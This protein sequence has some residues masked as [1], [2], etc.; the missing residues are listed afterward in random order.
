[1]RNGN[2]AGNPSTLLLRAVL[3]FVLAAAALKVAAPVAVPVVFSFYLAV[4]VR[5]LDM[6][7]RSV[8]PGK[9]R[10]L[11]L[12]LTL[13][14]ILLA[15]ALIAATVWFGV[16]QIRDRAPVYADAAARQWNSLLT[17]MDSHDLP[18]REAMGQFPGVI[19]RM[20]SFATST[21]AWIWH[22]AVLAMIIFFFTTLLLVEW[23]A[24][25]K[26]A[27]SAVSGETSAKVVSVV[28]TISVKVRAYLLTRTAVS[29]IS[30]LSAGLWL[31]AAGV[32]LAFVWGFLTFVLNYI[33][34][35]GS[36][37]SV[38]APSLLAFIQLGFGRAVLA[39]TGL[40][41]IEQIVGM[42]L[43]PKMQGRAMRVSPFVLLVSML[44]WGWMWGG[45]GVI[46]SV[47][48]TVTLLAVFSKIDTLEPAAVLMRKRAPEK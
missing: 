1:M 23:E 32:D 40:L 26:R 13:L 20:V 46:L 22:G 29:L 9:L 16:R 39:A 42:Y 30:G 34:Y 31:W 6:R 18:F 38:I 8:L 33:P 25:I 24:W 37:L 14:V 15:A 35:L 43:E 5:P 19:D 17:W 45:L 12:L 3:T 41:A 28:E 27:E 7:I 36:T 48:L 21:V 4:L 47:P 2:G 10:R 44:F 11:S